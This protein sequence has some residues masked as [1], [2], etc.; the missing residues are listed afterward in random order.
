MPTW[1]V[2]LIKLIV[3]AVVVPILGYA[4]LLTVEF[5]QKAWRSNNRRQKWIAMLVIAG[6]YLLLNGWFH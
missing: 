6:V 5:V 2:F 3:F 1:K 4:L